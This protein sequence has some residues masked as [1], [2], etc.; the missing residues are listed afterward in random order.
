[1]ERISKERCLNVVQQRKEIEKKDEEFFL[2]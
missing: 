2:S 1:M